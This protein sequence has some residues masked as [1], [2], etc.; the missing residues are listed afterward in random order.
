MRKPLKVC[1]VTGSRA[2]CWLMK[3]V[4]YKLR[5]SDAFDLSIIAMGSLVSKQFGK[6]V[7]LFKQDGFIVNEEIET[8]IAGDSPAAVSKT[9]GLTMIGIAEAYSRIKPDLILIPGDRYEILAAAAAALVSLIPIAHFYGGDITE[10]AYDDSIRHAITK[11]SHFH[12]VSNEESKKRVIQMGEKPDR[13]FNTGS[14]AIDSLLDIKFLSR[15]ELEKKLNFNFKKLTLLIT[16]H[17]ETLSNNS[18]GQLKEFLR[19]LDEFD[20][21]ETAFLFTS[22]NADNEGLSFIQEIK[23][24]CNKKNNTH[25]FANL[26]Q[27]VYGSLI[28]EVNVVVGNSSSGLYEVPSFKTPTVNIGDRQTGRLKASSVIDCPCTKDDIVRS[29]KDAITLD[30]QFSVNPYGDGH[31]SEKIFEKLK[32]I[33]KEGLSSRKNF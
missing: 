32:L 29:I 3:S 14:P 19:A 28:R 26:G 31:A 4:L 7:D 25:F 20:A 27:Q 18:I 17:P 15:E 23:S 21:E 9:M 13:V 8:L 11:M 30:C 22:P 10:G 1:F 33:K 5:D 24:F 6:A 16:F 12:F 2:D